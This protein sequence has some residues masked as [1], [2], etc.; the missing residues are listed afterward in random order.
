MHRC[1]FIAVLLCFF[2]AN[3]QEISDKKFEAFNR[4][5]IAGSKGVVVVNFW[6]TWCRPCI[7]ELPFFEK[8]NSEMNSESFRMYLVNLDFNSKFKTVATDFVKRKQIKSEV[9]H[10]NDTDP[11][12]WINKVD[13]SWSGAIPATVIYNDGK[14]VFFK[15]GEMTEE[16]LREAISKIKNK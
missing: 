1:F 15:E 12:V 11:N 3:A 5:N 9:I 13:S 2:S 6:A 16:Q 10:I 4:E 7:E 8:V 14:K